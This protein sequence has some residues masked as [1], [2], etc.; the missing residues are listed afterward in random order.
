[1]TATDPESVRTIHTPST[2][3]LSIA[4]ADNSDALNSNVDPSVHVNSVK[5]GA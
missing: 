1:M 4:A 3:A 5:L 2:D